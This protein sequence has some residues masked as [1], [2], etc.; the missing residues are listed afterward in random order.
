MTSS[1]CKFYTIFLFL[2]FALILFSTLEVQASICPRLSATW[3]KP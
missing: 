3:N 1:P 2:S